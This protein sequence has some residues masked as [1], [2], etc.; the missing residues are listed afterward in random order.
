[1][2]LCIFSLYLTA[3]ACTGTSETSPSS[4]LGTPSLQLTGEA[5]GTTWNVKVL[6]L[7]ES[8]ITKAQS[9]NKPS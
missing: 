6:G 3:V 4:S 7:E 1:M 9:K 8:K 5:L 2:R